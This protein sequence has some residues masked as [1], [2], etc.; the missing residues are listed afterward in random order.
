MYSYVTFWYTHTQPFYD[1]LSGTT[2]VDWYQKRHSSTHFWNVLWESVIILDF[3]SSGENNRG[4]CTDNPA[5]HHPIR[6]IDVP[7]S[8]IPP[9]L[10]RMPSCRNPPSLTWL[11]TGTKYAG[12]HT[13][14]L[15]CL[16]IHCYKNGWQCATGFVISLE[17]RRPVVAWLRCWLF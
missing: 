12:L 1:P 6:T 17:I 11:E 7:T 10:C 14:R 13:W 15:G 9:I 3:M 5:G 16:L 8:I 4:K 2:R